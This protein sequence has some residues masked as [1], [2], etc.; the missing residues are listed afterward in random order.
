VALGMLKVDFFASHFGR[1]FDHSRERCR[2]CSG[3]VGAKGSGFAAKG[4]T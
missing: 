1:R 3:L 4:S 2:D